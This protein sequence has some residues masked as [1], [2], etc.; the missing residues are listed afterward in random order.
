MSH[1]LGSWV[2]AGPTNLTFEASEQK[3]IHDVQ[4][5]LEHAP[6]IWF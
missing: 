3:I 5:M 6:V 4:Q 1:E 2:N